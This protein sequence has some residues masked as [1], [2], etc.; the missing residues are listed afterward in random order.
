MLNIDNED[1]KKGIAST[2]SNNNNGS[3]E[4]A[5]LL[6]SHP[7]SPI[8]KGYDSVDLFSPKRYNVDPF[9]FSRE[10]TDLL[11]ADADSNCN[12]YCGSSDS[13]EGVAMESTKGLQ[14]QQL[15]QQQQH[16]QQH[17]TIQSNMNDDLEQQQRSK[18]Q[19]RIQQRQQQQQNCQRSIA[20]GSVIN[21]IIHYQNDNIHGDFNNKSFLNSNNQNKNCTST[22][23]IDQSSQTT[24]LSTRIRMESSNKYHFFSLIEDYDFNTVD[25]QKSF[26]P[27]L[28]TLVALV[29]R[30]Y[31]LAISII[32]TFHDYK[33]ETSENGHDS[34][35]FCSHLT[36]I[37]MML[38]MT[39]QLT[40]C[41]LTF[42]ASTHSC[43]GR[44]KHHYV[45]Y[46][47][48][49]I[50][51]LLW[52]KR[53]NHDANYNTVGSS[54]HS[55]SS[56][57]GHTL[58]EVSTSDTLAYQTSSKNI[59]STTRP[60]I[61]VCFN[62]LLYTLV[63]PAEFAVAVGFW[64]FEYDGQVLEY[65]NIYK[66]GIIAMLLLIDGNI[67]GRIP[68]RIKHIFVA[69]IYGNFYV[70]YSIYFSFSDFGSSHNHGVIYDNLNWKDD[71]WGAI[72]MSLMLM[73]VV[74][75][76][77][78]MLCYL[79]SL[80]SLQ[81]GGSR[82]SLCGSSCCGGVKSDEYC[83]CFKCCHCCWYSFCNFTFQGGRR[84]L[85]HPVGNCEGQ[86]R[87]IMSQPWKR[88]PRKISKKG[89]EVTSFLSSHPHGYKS[90]Q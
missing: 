37:T 51:P 58:T 26:A 22:T 9:S 66:H 16:Q 81:G 3:D 62:W 40:S 35:L 45:L 27:A 12:S 7:L 52:N 6:S 68:L 14:Q 83:W 55:S 5:R 44:K 29:L 86:P 76:F 90:L 30:F 18:E 70:L 74:L 11:H 73:Y 82:Q 33:I 34:I 80:L 28:P 79:I 20:G 53:S 43:T 77:L 56:T 71:P 87:Y 63:L 41:F 23:T 1:N 57:S 89:E 59:T 21:G 25:V 42:V 72:W 64:L 46:Q 13:E 38:T 50:K 31:W 67:I 60:S 69:Y 65:T 2:T 32:F 10:Q 15:Q 75:P 39:Y 8:P 49:I 54:V 85:Y 61:L 88:E 4:L 36:N 24:T 19:H 17:T 84:I 48:T 47:P 78:F